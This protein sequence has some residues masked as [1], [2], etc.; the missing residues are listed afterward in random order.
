M[1]LS[2]L[3]K[4]PLSDRDWV[5][6]ILIGCVISIVPIVNLLALG[7][8]LHCLRLGMQ[9]RAELPVWEDWAEL[10]QE[11][12]FALLI[13]IIYLGIP[14]ILL[15]FLSLI[16]ILGPLV[17]SVLLL[18]AGLLLPAA[19]ASYAVRGNFVD[20][21]QIKLIFERTSQVMQYYLLAYISMVV[22]SS[23]GLLIIFSLPVLSFIG[24]LLLFYA[25]L[26]FFNLVGQLLGE[27]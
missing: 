14:F 22:I 13:I 5:K 27:S 15:P 4:Y 21:L 3:I 12:F 10:F 18:L 1:D 2:E 7:Y 8:F 23:L 20:A 16:P 9:G 19:L 25:S 11:G 24:V 6:K 26:V 17:A